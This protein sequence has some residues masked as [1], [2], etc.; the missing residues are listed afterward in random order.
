MT[1]KARLSVSVDAE[2]VS[3][4]QA[5]VTAGTADS[6]S[7]WVSEG[8]R[9]Q[10]EHDR[11]I[12]ALADFISAYEAE[13]GVITDEEMLEAERWVRSRAI[14]VPGEPGSRRRARGRGAA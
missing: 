7:A 4:A 6:V 13:R 11:R 9:R 3:A 10:A 12:I 14:S 8:M 2:L 1:T 5:A